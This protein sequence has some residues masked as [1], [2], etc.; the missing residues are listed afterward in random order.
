MFSPLQVISCYSLLQSPLK[1]SDLVKKASEMGYQALALTD[2]NVM[3]GVLDF[4]K[5]CQKYH[6][7]PLLG[8][9]LQLNDTRQKQPATM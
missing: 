5:A 9:T 2:I 8:L 6:I 4:Y 1:I 3:Y 7:K